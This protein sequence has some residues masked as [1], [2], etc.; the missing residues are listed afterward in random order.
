MLDH[1]RLLQNVLKLGQEFVRGDDV[2]DLGLRGNS[3]DH[4]LA[5]FRRFFEL[6]AYYA[7]TGI[8]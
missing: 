6:S 7:C 1:G 5:M 2:G 3:I 8:G 4:I